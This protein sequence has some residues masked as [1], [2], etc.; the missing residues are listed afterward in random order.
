[1]EENERMVYYES[2]NEDDY[3][4]IGQLE[5]FED[6]DTIVEIALGDLNLKNKAKSVTIELFLREGWEKPH[7]H[8]YNDHFNCAIRLDTNEYF[9]HNKYKDKL[10]DKQAKLFDNFM[11]SCD[12][13]VKI[14]RWTMV[15]YEFNREFPRH[16]IDIEDKPD[17]SM[18]NYT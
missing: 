7:L 2:H 17:Y 14:N 1:M 6:H 5:L 16:I 9:I 8:L 4:L 3:I 12:K 15:K 13:G 10:N 11:N 18:L